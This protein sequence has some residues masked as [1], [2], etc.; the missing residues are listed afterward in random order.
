MHAS[1]NGAKKDI[2]TALKY[3]ESA[4]PGNSPAA[5]FMVGYAYYNG[6]HRPID[7][8]KA[9]S[10]LKDAADAGFDE[11][12]TIVADMYIR[13]LG[14]PQSYSN[15]VT[16]LQKAVMQ[17]NTGAMM[18]LAE[19][20]IEGKK[21]AKDIYYAH[22]LY[23]LASVRGVPNA[24]QKRDAVEGA[25]KVDEVLIAQ[26][27]AG[28]YKENISETTGYIRKTFGQNLISYFN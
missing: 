8:A 14:F 1:G 6:K 3:F 19:I 21:Y 24:M 17:G 5:K 4:L 28:R 22:V 23:N 18:T 15:G 10:L 9:S 11:A 27:R 13:G 7:Y 16:Y 26:E 2:E 25:M 12:Q 20:L